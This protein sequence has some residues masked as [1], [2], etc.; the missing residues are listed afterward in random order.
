MTTT[1][2]IALNA[3]LAAAV[4]VAILR[5]LV[6]GIRSDRITHAHAFQPGTVDA[7]LRDQLA[8]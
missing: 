2:L 5:L 3:V 4:V 6:H 8:A 1:S 7:D